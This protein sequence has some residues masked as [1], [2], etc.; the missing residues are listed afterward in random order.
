MQKKP[1]C[2]SRMLI[3]L[4]TAALCSG[5]LAVP[6]AAGEEAPSWPPGICPWISG[7]TGRTRSW[8]RSS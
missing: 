8:A 6:A 7:M 4:L 1:R 2:I 3:W 5:L